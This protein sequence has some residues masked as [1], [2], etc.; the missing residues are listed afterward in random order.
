V[1]DE[2]PRY[3]FRGSVKPSAEVKRP[4]KAYRNADTTEANGKKS[5]SATID[6]FDV[7]D[8]YGGWWGISAGEVDQALAAHREPAPCARRD[9][10]HHELRLGRVRCVGDRDRG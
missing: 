7:I 8:S 9:H 4:V 10:P 5:T 1:A 2:T 6:I 3:R